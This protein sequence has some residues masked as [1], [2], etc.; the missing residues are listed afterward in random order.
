M[1]D[2]KPIEEYWLT[3][4]YSGPFV[5]L[6]LEETDE[7]GQR[8]CFYGDR[9][10]YTL[11]AGD[12]LRHKSDHKPFLITKVEAQRGLVWLKEG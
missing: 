6:A 11:K 5:V 4:D 8:M 9:D 1:K 12:H 3:S 2:Q 10:I 7:F